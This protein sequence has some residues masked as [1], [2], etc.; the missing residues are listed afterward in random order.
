[1]IR[2]LGYRLLVKPEKL[3]EVD[4]IFARAKKAG[5]EFAESSAEARREQVAVDRGTVVAIGEL[6]FQ[7]FKTEP[8]VKVGAVIG[9]TRY[10][11][12]F[13]KDEDGTEYLVLNDED[14]ICEYTR[15][16]NDN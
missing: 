2:I 3:E 11:G 16:L 7:D 10:G 5:I 14:I 13:V 9:Y 15:E 1:M 8:W 6:A 12:K 4:P